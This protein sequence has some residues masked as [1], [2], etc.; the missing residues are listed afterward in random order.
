MRTV[1]LIG[2]LLPFLYYA[3]KDNIF[4]FRGRRVSLTEHLLHVAIGVTLVPAI[5]HAFVGSQTFMVAGFLLFL[6]VGGIDEYVFH[7]GLPEVES[8]LHAKEHLGLLIFVVVS[9]TTNWLENHDWEL[10][11][12]FDGRL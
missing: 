1:I 5:G 2:S 6:V 9:M 8:D 11:S 7:H 3:T 4:H 10:G 12:L